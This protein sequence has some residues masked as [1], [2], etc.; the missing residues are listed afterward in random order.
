MLL[1]EIKK[2]CKIITNEEHQG[3]ELYFD[4]KP[5]EEIITILKENGY[6]WHSTIYWRICI[7]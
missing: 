3:E 2:D 1:E 7:I 6:R 5:T 4:D